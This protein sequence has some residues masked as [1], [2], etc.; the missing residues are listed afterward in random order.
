M[1]KLLLY[2]QNYGTMGKYKSMVLWKNSGTI[3]RTIMELRPHGR[4]PKGKKL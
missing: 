3:P 2:G 1:E 4:L